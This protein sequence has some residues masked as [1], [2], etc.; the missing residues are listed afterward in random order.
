MG[1]VQVGLPCPY[2]FGAA[3]ID[4]AMTRTTAQAQSKT[5]A[6]FTPGTQPPSTTKYDS[7]RLSILESGLESKVPAQKELFAIDLHPAGAGLAADGRGEMPVRARQAVVLAM[8]ASYSLSH[9]LIPVVVH[10]LVKPE[11]TLNA[12][13]AHGWSADGRSFVCVVHHWF[14]RPLALIRSSY[15]VWL[16]RAIDRRAPG[17]RG[18]AVFDKWLAARRGELRCGILP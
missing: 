12:Q 6:F 3:K 4:L 18:F 17:L 2:T 16:D 14:N 1:I 13:R 5:G 7:P 10:G 15:V 11:V 9:T 8:L